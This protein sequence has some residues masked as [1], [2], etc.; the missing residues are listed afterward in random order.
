VIEG[1]VVRVDAHTTPPRLHVRA[2]S[3]ILSIIVRPETAIFTSEVATG[4]GGAASL[5]QIYRGDFVRVTIDPSGYA[6]AIRASY[7]ELSGR[8]DGLGGRALYLADGQ[9]FRLADEA[10]IIVDG[11]EATRDLLRQG[12]DVTLRLNPQTN[13]VLAVRATSPVPPPRLPR[14]VPAPPVIEWVSVNAPGPLGIGDTLVVSVRGTPGGEA[15]FDIARVERGVRMVEGP[16]GRYTGRYTIR[17]GEAVGAGAVTVRLRVA[18]VE[19]TR[20][21]DTVTVD[22]LP[23]EFV[24]R[25]PEPDS[26][27]RSAQPSIAVWFNDRGPSGVNPGTVLTALYGAYSVWCVRRYD[28]TRAGALA[29]FTCFL[30]GFVVLTIVGVHFRG[31]N[32]V[33][34]WSPADWPKH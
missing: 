13:E 26:V 1:T 10:L 17:P 20:V 11:R 14:I 16:V 9:V 21:A 32:W 30:C 28:S 3:T 27:V 8:L 15:W 29:L 6:T 23:P 33:F 19:T 5:D 2:D 31:P 7:R 18:G 12:M 24:R 4:R 34:Y 25:V 22:G